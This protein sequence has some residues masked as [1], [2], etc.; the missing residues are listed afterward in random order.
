MNSSTQTN[1]VQLDLLKDEYLKALAI[2]KYSHSAE[3]LNRLDDAIDAYVYF[4][5]D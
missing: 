1:R 2:Y 3:A 5:L 4:K